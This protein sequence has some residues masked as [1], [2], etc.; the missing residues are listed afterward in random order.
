VLLIR[1]DHERRQRH[2]QHGQV[3]VVRQEERRVD[4]HHG[5]QFENPPPALDS[6]IALAYRLTESIKSFPNWSVFG[7]ITDVWL[8]KDNNTSEI[9]PN[10][11]GNTIYLTPGARVRLNRNLA[12]T[13]APT[14][15]VVQNLDGDQI[16]AQFKLALTFSI[17]F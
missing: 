11:G 6:G 8:G 5:A 7:E 16:Q 4:D 17:S 13:V 2:D 1:A 15:P 3:V 12:L 9:N 14:F 10:S